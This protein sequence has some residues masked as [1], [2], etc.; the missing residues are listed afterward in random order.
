MKDLQLF[1]PVTQM[2]NSSVLFPVIPAYLR[3]SAEVIE[4]GKA[5]VGGAVT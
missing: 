1:N 5:E 4:G 3:T 2:F